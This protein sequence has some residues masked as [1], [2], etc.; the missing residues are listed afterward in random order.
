MLDGV[1]EVVAIGAQLAMYT[2]HVV[3]EW[4]DLAPYNHVRGVTLGQHVASTLVT[5]VPLASS[6]TAFALELRWL[7]IIAA[8]A[9]GLLFLAEICNWWIPYLF[10]R[11]PWEVNPETYATWGFDR[12]YKLL[13]PFRGHPVVPDAQ[14]LVVM[15]LTGA[16]LATQICAIVR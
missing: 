12:T 7:A 6:L 1:I 15:A 5:A 11:Y 16:A 4:I 3:T 10:A 8:V 9:W 2:H 14:H 13:P